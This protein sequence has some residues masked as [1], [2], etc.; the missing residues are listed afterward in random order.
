MAAGY[1]KYR[2]CPHP[3]GLRQ[4]VRYGNSVAVLQRWLTALLANHLLVLSANRKCASEPAACNVVCCFT[5]SF[6][7]TYAV[8]TDNWCLSLSSRKE[9]KEASEVLLDPCWIRASDLHKHVPQ[10]GAQRGH[11]WNH[12]EGE[13]LNMLYFCQWLQRNLKIR[14]QNRNHRL[15]CWY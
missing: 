8:N 15:K 6:E 12:R 7:S 1:R 3:L 14:K 2:F 11:C 9:W 5:Y 13:M 10:L 4:E